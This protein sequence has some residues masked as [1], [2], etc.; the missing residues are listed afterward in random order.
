M[1]ADE[2]HKSWCQAAKHIKSIGRS[3]ILLKIKAFGKAL[4]IVITY[5]TLITLYSNMRMSRDLLM[6]LLMIMGRYIYMKQQN[7]ALKYCSNRLNYLSVALFRSAAIA[8]TNY[9]NGWRAW[10]LT[11]PCSA[12]DFRGTSTLL[13]RHYVFD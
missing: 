3:V 5:I 1:R 10:K 4:R 9:A 11:K 2:D 7:L 6:P 8:A 13:L 12:K